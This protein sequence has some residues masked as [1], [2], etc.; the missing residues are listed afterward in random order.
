[1]SSRYS[2]QTPLKFHRRRHKARL[3]RA[4]VRGLTDHGD[5]RAGITRQVH[6]VAGW[7]MHAGRRTKGL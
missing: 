5:L 2:A 4:A 6:P 1:M 3:A 7:S